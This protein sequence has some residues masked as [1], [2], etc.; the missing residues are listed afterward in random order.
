MI[1]PLPG[2]STSVTSTPTSEPTKFKDDGAF[3]HDGTWNSF[4]F[5]PPLTHNDC[6]ELV[7]HAKELGYRMLFRQADYSLEEIQERLV[8]EG[9]SSL[10]NMTA[11]QHD[12]SP[13]E[14]P[15]TAEQRMSQRMSKLAPINDLIITDPYLFTSSRKRDSNDYATAVV[16]MIAPALAKGLCITAIVCPS[17][18]D[19]TVRTAVLEQ[20]HARG[21]HLDITVMESQDFHDRFWIADRARGLVV[22]TSLNKIGSRIFFVD[23]LSESDVADVV[24]EVDAIVGRPQDLT[25]SSGSKSLTHDLSAIA[26]SLGDRRRED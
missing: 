5:D 9:P 24:S 17:G 25:G 10:L 18:N 21:Q 8:E 1:D 23:E 15:V 22:G 13:K 14:P 6:L 19:D 26:D 3:R 7:S 11:L 4:Q 12:I 2:A 20:L 16:G